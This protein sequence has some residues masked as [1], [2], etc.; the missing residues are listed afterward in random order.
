[1]T[2]SGHT[3]SIRNTLNMIE[4]ENFLTSKNDIKIFL[5][6]VKKLEPERFKKFA[7]RIKALTKNKNNNKNSII[8]QIRNLI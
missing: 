6:E 1:M 7:F 2:S 8:I 4:E 3:E 5:K